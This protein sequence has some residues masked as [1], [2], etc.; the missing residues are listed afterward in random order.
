MSVFKDIRLL[1]ADPASKMYLIRKHIFRHLIQA[2]STLVNLMGPMVP[3]SSGTLDS[4]IFI[5]GCSRSGSTV[6]VNAVAK[7]R[8]LVNWSEAAQIF[9]L[10]YYDPDVDHVKVK[11]DV[12]ESDARRIQMAFNLCLRL[13][14]KH[15]FVNKHPQNS[16]RIEYLKV[17]FP[18]AY[19]IHLIRDGRAVI[20]SHLQKLRR[21]RFRFSYPFGNFPKPFRWRKYLDQPPLIQYAHQ[22]NEIVRYVRK[23]AAQTLS[24][25][26]YLEIKYETFCEDTYRVLREIDTF[27]GLD[28]S[29]RLSDTTLSEIESRN[30]KWREHLDRRDIQAIMPI[31]G[32]L[33]HDL[34]YTDCNSVS[35]WEI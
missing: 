35:E 6:L 20:N 13:Y 4:P 18:D 17:L 16:L 34:G 3:D 21:E 14:G 12:A 30:H 1:G 10:D 2:G 31:I 29:R 22:W 27:C 23:T 8:D 32:D 33:L 26:Q 11:G 28:P 24:G 5:V 7:H 15:R 9:D 19:F 25:A